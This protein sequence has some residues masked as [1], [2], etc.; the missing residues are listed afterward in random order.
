MA[1]LFVFVTHVA[2]V[3]WPRSKAVFAALHADIKLIVMDGNMPLMNGS[4]KSVISENIR[5]L[6]NEGRPEAQAVAI[7]YS[8]AGKGRKRL[9]K[10]AKSAS[11]KPKKHSIVEKGYN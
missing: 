1:P 3:T 6:V 5:T 8:K 2:Q 11:T 4:S 7:A 9:D 10:A